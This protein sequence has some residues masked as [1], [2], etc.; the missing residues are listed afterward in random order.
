MENLQ[1]YKIFLVVMIILLANRIWEVII[2]LRNEKILIKHYNAKL[3]NP[4][5]HKFVF[6]FHFIWFVCL[7]F[8]SI[9]YQTIAKPIIAFVCYF[10]L[11]VAYLLRAESMRVLGV[12]WTAKIYLLDNK[13][14]RDF[15]IFRYIA[16]PSYLAVIL[17]FIAVP[18]LFNAKWTLIVF[19]VINFVIIINRVIMERKITGRLLL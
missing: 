10:L 13:H 9:K 6:G 1:F 18:L 17:E 2:S 11:L 8:E 19:S 12:F 14:L 3:L 16:H 15:G 4:D 7:I 5:E